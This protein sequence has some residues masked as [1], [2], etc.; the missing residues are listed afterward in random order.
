MNN[1]VALG[2]IHKNVRS[3]GDGGPQCGHFSDKGD[4]SDADVCTFWC[5]KLRIFRNL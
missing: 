5:K 2:A 1:S 3:D 4:S